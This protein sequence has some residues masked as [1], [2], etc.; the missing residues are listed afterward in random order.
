IESII[1]ECET[2]T[3]N[4]SEYQCCFDHCKIKY[5]L[6]GTAVETELNW[7]WNIS[8]QIYWLNKCFSISKILWSKYQIHLIL[9]L[10]EN[11]CISIKHF[12][13]N[14]DLQLYERKL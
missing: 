11:G 4:D 6:F 2:R 5:K 1:D 7:R 3:C 12:F 9:C 13:S 10:W 8:I 14:Q